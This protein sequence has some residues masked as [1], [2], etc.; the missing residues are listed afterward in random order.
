MGGS[1]LESTNRP[2]NAVHACA[3]CHMYIESHREWA[4]ERG[5]LLTQSSDPSDE[6]VHWRL[7]SWVLLRNDGTKQPVG[8]GDTGPIF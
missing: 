2:S 4:L 7:A 6:P 8:N 3:R 5:F 1:R